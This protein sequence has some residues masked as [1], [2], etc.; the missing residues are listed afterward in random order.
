MKLT[1][2]LVTIVSSLWTRYSIKKNIYANVRVDVTPPILMILVNNSIPLLHSQLI[3]T[4]CLFRRA[5]LNVTG[6]AE[7]S[8]LHFVYGLFFVKY[9]RFACS[10]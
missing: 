6:S 1:K 10:Y 7:N 8:W 2:N 3:L 9:L 5:S 4:R